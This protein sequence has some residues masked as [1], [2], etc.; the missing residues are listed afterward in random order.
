M[1]VKIIEIDKLIEEL[2]ILGESTHN[3][4]VFLNLYNKAKLKGYDG[5]LEDFINYVNQLNKSLNKHIE[6]NSINW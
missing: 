6:W 4:E 1:T 2:P 5:S 3:S